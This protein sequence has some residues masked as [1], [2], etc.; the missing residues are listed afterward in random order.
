MRLQVVRR[1]LNKRMR[2]AASTA[3]K[4]AP[5]FARATWRVSPFSGSGPSA[6]SRTGRR[7]HP[8]PAA[9]ATRW[10]GGSAAR[11]APRPPHAQDLDRG[12][13]GGARPASSRALDP[14][15]GGDARA[16][17]RRFSSAVPVADANFLLAPRLKSASPDAVGAAPSAPRVAGS[18]PADHGSPAPERGPR[19]HAPVRRPDDEE[20]GIVLAAEHRGGAPADPARSPLRGRRREEPEG[21]AAVAAKKPAVVKKTVAEYVDETLDPSRRA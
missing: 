7:G 16:R 20:F 17:P 3:R 11:A 2:R 6:P 8:G 1:G 10:P 14:P 18:P 5:F 21:S 13:T 12:S 19:G 4:S 9:R 15:P